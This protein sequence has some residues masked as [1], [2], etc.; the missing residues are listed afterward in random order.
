MRVQSRKGCAL[1]TLDETAPRGM[2]A[3]YREQEGA[4]VASVSRGSNGSVD[5]KRARIE[6][7]SILRRLLRHGDCCSQRACNGEGSDKR[8]EGILLQ[9][10][11]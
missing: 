5:G 10:I 2:V 4:L 11:S 7:N 1:L 9:H 8:E 6:V 3:S